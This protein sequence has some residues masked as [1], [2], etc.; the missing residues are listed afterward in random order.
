MPHAAGSGGLAPAGLD[1][2]VVLPDLGSGVAAGGA[3]LLLDVERNL[4]APA[5]QGVRLVAPFSER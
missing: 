3:H 4:A 5:A 2:P 1:G